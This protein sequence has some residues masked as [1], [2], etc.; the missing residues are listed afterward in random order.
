MSDPTRAEKFRT[1]ALTGMR[2]F[3]MEPDPWQMDVITCEDKRLLL[4]CSRQ[5]GKSTTVAVLGVLESVA[6]GGTTVLI[7]APSLRQSRLLFK[8]AARF[9]NRLGQ[10]YIKNQTIHEL[11][12]KNGSQIVCLPCKEETIRGYAN[13]HLLIIDE[14]ARVPDDIYLAVSPMLAV[15]DGR[16]IC[17]STPHGRRGF[18]Y[19]AWARG[20][21][22]WKRIE[23]P[24]SQ[25]PRISAIYLERVRRQMGESW[26]N[27]EFCCSFEALE[28][29]VYPDFARCL[30]KAADLPYHL[31][32]LLPFGENGRCRAPNPLYAVARPEGSWYGGIDFGLTNPFAAVWGCLDRD[33]VFWLVGEHYAR[34]KTLDYHVQHMPQRVMWYADPAGAREIRELR[35][36]DVKV[37]KAD[38]ERRA[39]IATV[40][41]RLESGTLKILEGAC[42]NLL[43]EA[44]LYRYDTQ[45][46]SEEPLKEQDHALDALRYLF[47]ILD[48]KKMALMSKRRPPELPPEAMVR[49]PPPDPQSSPQ[50]SSP[51]ASQPPPKRKWLSI[52]NEQLWTRL[53]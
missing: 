25:V 46:R 39:G 31:R 34:D 12:L 52:Y 21:V 49:N 45:S 44:Q 42:P 48:Y 29:L 15:S 33:D 36:A 13:V 2:H 17:L 16:L 7:V 10:K 4:N 28:G 26:Y 47:S 3:G 8:T 1:T 37:R 22:D 6:Y 11:T 51:A 5:A 50:G 27:Q 43:T 24:V 14:A 53:E 41:R 32:T 23:V 18:F 40:R 38:N 19:E 20:G 35:C 9:L 30:V